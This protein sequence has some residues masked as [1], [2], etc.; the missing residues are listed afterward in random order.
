MDN[1]QYIQVGLHIER[2]HRSVRS[3]RRLASTA[4]RFSRA[5]CCSCLYDECFEAMCA[6]QVRII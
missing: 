4:S 3:S 6:F 2:T 1:Q 5:T